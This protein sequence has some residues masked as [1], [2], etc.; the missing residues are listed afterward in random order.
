MCCT[1]KTLGIGGIRG[2][3]EREK[4]NRE[5]ESSSCAR[6]RGRVEPRG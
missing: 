4:M 5:R 2:E 3:E 1:W 6:P